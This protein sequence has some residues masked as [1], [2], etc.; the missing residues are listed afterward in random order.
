MTSLTRNELDDLAKGIA[1]QL[2]DEYSFVDGNESHW[3]T[4]IAKNGS[5]Y[6]HVSNAQGSKGKQVHVFPS[7][8]LIKGSRWTFDEERKK[9]TTS[10]NCAVTKGAAG[11]AKDIR[12]RLLPDTEALFDLAAKLNGETDSYCTNMNALTTELAEAIGGRAQADDSNQS[13][14]V[15]FSY[16]GCYGDLRP[17]GCEDGGSVTM[18]LRGIPNALAIEICKLIRNGAQE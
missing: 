13:Y 7:L 10:I 18:D 5:E 12:R 6:L 2:G 17:N 14:R 3:L 1:K 16:D 11:I 8:P 9:R 15:H 4:S